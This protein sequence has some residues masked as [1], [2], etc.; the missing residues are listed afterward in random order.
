MSDDE[1]P[2]E[3][4]SATSFVVDNGQAPHVPAKIT[5]RGELDASTADRFDHA[6]SQAI[7]AGATFVLVDLSEVEFLD[8]SALRVIV[9]RGNALK[10]LGGRLVIEGLSPA[11]QR[12]LEIT[13][14]LE[15]YRAPAGT[16]FNA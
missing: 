8:S 1:G 4:T 9:R 10:E 14:L 3:E 13:G 15:D 12:I 11:A 16:D 6:I 7:S 2:L 5:A